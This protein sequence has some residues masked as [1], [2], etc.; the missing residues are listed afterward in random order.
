M[1]YL[2][3]GVHMQSQEGVTQ[4]DSAAM[5]M[6]ALSTQPLTQALRY[7]TANDDVKEVWYVDNGS[8]VGSLA[9]M[10]KWWEYLKTKGPEAKDFWYYPKPEKTIILINDYLV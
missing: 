2:E 5:A 6:Y 7:E 1:L 4:R 10:K 8:P 3:N 9:G